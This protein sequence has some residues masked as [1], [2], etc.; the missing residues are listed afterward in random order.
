MTA[1]MVASSEGHEEV[2]NLLLQYN[3]TVDVQNDV[4]I[5]YI[6]KTNISVLTVCQCASVKTFYRE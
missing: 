6:P 3:A 2:V 4:S 1:L 5:R